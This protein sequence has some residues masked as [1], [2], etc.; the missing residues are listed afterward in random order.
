MRRLIRLVVIVLAAILV[1]AAVSKTARAE[2]VNAPKAA[3]G[4]AAAVEVA[5]VWH[6]PLPAPHAESV[7]ADPRGALTGRKR[8]T[9]WL[10]H[11]GTEHDSCARP[12]TIEGWRVL[13]VSW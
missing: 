10:L 4:K 7:L 12:D 9:G 1:T 6:A 2:M 11:Y 8:G 3:T 13:C 5:P